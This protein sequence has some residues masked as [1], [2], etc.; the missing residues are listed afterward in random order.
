MNRLRL[1]V[2]ALVC[3]AIGAVVSFRS[4]PSEVDDLPAGPVVVEP[5]QLVAAVPGGQAQAVV[6][7]A[8]GEGYHVQAHRVPFAYLHPTHVAFESTQLLEVGTPDYPVGKPYVLEGSADTLAVY[9]RHVEIVVPVMVA[10]TARAGTYT[11]HGTLAYQ[12]CDDRSCYRP[13]RQS[14]E[15]AVQ[16]R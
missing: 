1:T 6:R 10:P 8:I 12:T 3:L 16:V 11:V 9:G 4:T 14:L 7:L 5:S 2:G 13:V 15:L